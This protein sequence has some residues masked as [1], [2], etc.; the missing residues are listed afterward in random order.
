MA[1]VQLSICTYEKMLK[2]DVVDKDMCCQCGTCRAVCPKNYDKKNNNP[3]VVGALNSLGIKVFSEK[4]CQLCLDV[5]PIKHQ[6]PEKNIGKTVSLFR[7][8]ATNPEILKNCQDGGACTAFL[9]SLEEHTIIAAKN[10]KWSAKAAF[11]VSAREASTSKYSASS[12]LSLLPQKRKKIAFVGLPCQIRGITLAQEKDLLAEIDLKIG[13]FCTKNFVYE[14][15]KNV[16][17]K[18]GIKMDDIKKMKIEKKLTLILN[19]DNSQSIPLKKLG[20]CEIPGC[21]YCTDFCALD[22]DIAFGSAGSPEKYTTIITRTQKGD[23]FFKNAMQKG[24]I[25]AERKVVVKKIKNLQK[26]KM[27]ENAHE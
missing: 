8:Q 3:L 24:L 13:L 2:K 4:E 14:K 25:T 16:I 26:K 20:G 10:K 15:L 6:I 9:E 7:A 19:D 22:A 23:K 11:V 18:H 17:E 5:C 1:D 27:A 12:S 21:N